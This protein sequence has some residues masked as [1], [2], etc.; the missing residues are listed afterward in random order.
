MVYLPKNRITVPGKLRQG[1]GQG[2]GKDYE[3]WT[4]VGDFPGIKGW[5]S[6]INCL[7]TDRPA[8]SLSKGEN[9]LRFIHEFRSE[10]KDLQENFKL[11][12]D[13]V[14]AM[15]NELGI[16]RPKAWKE[17]SEPLSIDLRVTCKDPERG[18]WREAYDFKMESTL[19]N[20]RIMAENLV[21][22]ALCKYDHCSYELK[23]DKTLDFVYAKNLAF[24]R[25][26][27]DPAEYQHLDR[28]KMAIME[29]ILYRELSS[30]PLPL[31]YAC[32]DLDAQYALH[33]GTCLTLV[34]LLVWQ[35]FWGIDLHRK[36]VPAEER[37]EIL[38]RTNFEENDA[39]QSASH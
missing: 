2:E 22:Q 33:A 9:Y 37:I 16:K 14:F 38:E 3:P 34:C 36:F 7:K 4:Q 30:S 35:R 32:A 21:K 13:D 17:D 20:P 28:E 12:W 15:A 25:F 24:L 31:S 18:K 1:R 26:Y 8:D 5:S 23:T 19:H 27:Y 39:N 6:Y 11:E 29:P 10:V